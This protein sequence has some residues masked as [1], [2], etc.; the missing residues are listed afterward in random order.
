VFQS[1]PRVFVPGQVV[2]FPIP[3]GG[4]EMGV[5]GQIVIFGSLLM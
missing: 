4:D 1:S 5:G 2:L 3:F